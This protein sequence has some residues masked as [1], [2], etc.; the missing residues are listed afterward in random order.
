MAEVGFRL[1]DQES[2]VWVEYEPDDGFHPAGADDVVD[3]LRAAIAPAV[4]GARIVLDRVRAV[5]PDEIEVKIGLKVSGTANWVIAKAATEGNIE[6][7][8]TWKPGDRRAADGTGA[9]TA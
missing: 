7:T 6:I 3:S 4:D 2:V 5:A 9:P 1:D 8:L